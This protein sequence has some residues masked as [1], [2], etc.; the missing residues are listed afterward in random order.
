[1]IQERVMLYLNVDVA[2]A[3][4]IFKFASSPSL[5]ELFRD[6]TARVPAPDEED[7]TVAD[8]MKGQQR[9]LGSGS[10][11]TVFLQHLGIAAADVGFT[12]SSKD[13]GE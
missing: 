11:Y 2:T 6:V 13:P 12:F 7:K 1:M 5:I 4:S 9:Q 8:Y 3:G 10:D